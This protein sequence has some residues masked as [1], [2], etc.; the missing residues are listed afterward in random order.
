MIQFPMLNYNNSCVHTGTCVETK[1]FFPL[2]DE[3]MGYTGDIMHTG[4]N[5]WIAVAIVFWY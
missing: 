2:F 1:L 3:V 4:A 5:H